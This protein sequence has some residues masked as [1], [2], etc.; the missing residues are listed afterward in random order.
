MSLGWT[1]QNL[2]HHAAKHFLGSPAERWVELMSPEEQP[3]WVSWREVAE[4]ARCGFADHP[5]RC[6]QEDVCGPIHRAASVPYRSLADADWDF[7]ERRSFFVRFVE[8]DGSAG[9]CG[10]GP[11]GIVVIAIQRP[12]GERVAKTAYRASERRPTR[13]AVQKMRALASLGSGAWSKVDLLDLE[14]RLL[15][16]P[17]AKSPAV[18]RIAADLLKGVP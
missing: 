2:L 16:A 5:E 12:D 17:A 6:Q 18:E 1:P 8:A 15:G 13:S 9:L 14:T 4:S 7:A 11:R 3:Q 10:T